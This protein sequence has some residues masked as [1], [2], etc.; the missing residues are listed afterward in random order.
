VRGA[1][2]VVRTQAAADV[3]VRGAPLGQARAD[4]LHVALDR[5]D[6]VAEG[7]RVAAADGSRADDGQAAGADGQVVDPRRAARDTAAVKDGD[8]RVA[9]PLGHGHG[10]PSAC[11]A[12][13]RRPEADPRR[14]AD[15]V[16]TWRVRHLAA[17]GGRVGL[18][19]MNDPTLLS[20]D[21]DGALAEALDGL[22]ESSVTRADLL[23]RSVIAGGLGA[24]TAAMFGGMAATAAAQTTRPARAAVAPQRRFDLA[25]LRFG[26]VV[27]QLGAS[28]YQE[29][30]D[31]GQL[32]GETK[33]YARIA[34]R[35]ERAHVL[36]VAGAIGAL[37]ARPGP[38][39]AS[40]SAR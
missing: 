20:V 36:A 1:V 40:T 32:R 3:D 19:A 27:E 11:R 14:G 16:S 5:G 12:A 13:G 10:R 34:R 2:E 33:D 4:Q 35:D 29:A 8:L 26:L 9:Q 37:G 30:V 25:V 28:F 39:P 6:E 15:T 18:L 31:R 23:R 24:A 22:G 38:S 17:A 21:R 7:E